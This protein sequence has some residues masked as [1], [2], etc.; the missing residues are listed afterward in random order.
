VV[1]GRALV[2]DSLEARRGLNINVTGSLDD[3]PFEELT[4]VGETVRSSV[5][6]PRIIVAAG[7]GFDFM[8]VRR[9]VEKRSTGQVGV[10]S[11]ELGLYGPNYRVRHFGLDSDG[12]D[13]LPARTKAHG[14]EVVLLGKAADIVYCDGAVR[15]NMIPTGEVLAACERHLRDLPSGLVVANVQ[16]AD[17]AG[18]EGDAARYRGVLEEVDAFVPRLL[19]ALRPG[20]VLFV[21][22]DHGND[23]LFAHGQHTRE[24]TP[25]LV[26]GSAIRPT[27]LG[28][29]STL[30]DIAATIAELLGVGPVPAGTSFAAEMR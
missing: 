28:V 15:D 2:A 17:L 24:R 29:R 16:E 3:L 26:A 6:V 18:H 11:P 25:I 21:T 23:P 9:C 30:S 13:Q 27:A 12:D 5:A 8:D 14:Y 1:N 10:T 4:R 19:D 7:D 22:G 20:D